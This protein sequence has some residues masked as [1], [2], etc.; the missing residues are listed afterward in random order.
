MPGS[1]RLVRVG[2]LVFFLPFL[3]PVGERKEEKN[4]LR[5]PSLGTH[6]G[7]KSRC[8]LSGQKQ[9]AKARSKSGDAPLFDRS[10]VPSLLALGFPPHCHGTRCDI[11]LPNVSLSALH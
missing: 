2:Q 8:E 10:S 3:S 11:L 4:T 1:V 9:T 6:L 7:V 5:S